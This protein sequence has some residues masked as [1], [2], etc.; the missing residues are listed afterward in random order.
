MDF[1][2]AAR[3]HATLMR[4]LSET[5]GH[6]FEGLQAAARYKSQKLTNRKDTEDSCV[7]WTQLPTG[8]DTPPP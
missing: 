2:A 8:P 1:D 3:A 7:L 4:Q 5:A 6:P